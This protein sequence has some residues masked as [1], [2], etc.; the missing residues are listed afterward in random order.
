[1]DLGNSGTGVRL[2]LGLL[3][4]CPFDAV[5][6]GDESLRSRP[7]KRVTAPLSSMGARFESLEAPDRLPIH[8]RGGKL[9]PLQYD[10]PIASAQVK[11]A[12]MLA[13]LVGGVPVSLTEPGRSRDHTERMFR[14]VGVAVSSD[15]RDGRW[16]VSFADPPPVLPPLDFHVPGDFSS[17]AFLLVAGLLGVGAGSLTL[18]NVGLNPTRTG[19]LPLLARM[20]GEVAVEGGSDD[21]REPVG[22][23]KVAPAMLAGTEVSAEEV[24]PA[25]DEIPAL[26]ALASRARGVTRITGAGELRVKETDRIRALVEGM[27]ALGVDVEELE[28][29]LVLEGSDRPLRGTI[30]SHLDHRIAM[31]FGLLGALPGNE[32]RVLG[33]ECVDVSF[34]GFWET[35]A[36]IR[37]ERSRRATP[38][39]AAS[40]SRRGAVVTLDGPAGSGKSSTARE[41]ARRL[42]YR[43]LD[44]GALYRALTHALLEGG[45]GP[46]RW[47]EL[48]YGDLLGFDIRVDSGPDERL[49]VLLHGTMLEER[50]LRSREVTAHVSSLAR[51]PAV[52]AWLLER[53]REAGRQGALVA[54]G[55]D[56]GTVVFPDAEVKVF[57]VA[58]LQERARRRLRE[59]GT[60]NPSSSEV[61]EEAERIR[62]R[63]QR[64]SE[65]E[66]SPLRQAR[67]A[68]VLDTTGLTFEAQVEAIVARVRQRLAEPRSA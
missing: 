22:R 6:T 32:V 24:L 10:L 57:L 67:D 56:M 37:Q 52:R 60:E 11:S 26:V 3:A 62:G 14:Q 17:A 33:A 19:L 51:L 42:G 41:V 34:P 39:P 55:R 21:G 15:A 36:R 61:A 35:L 12:L 7:M 1:L 59:M 20:G 50:Q 25:I 13:G 54:E 2:L 28:D 58:D 64:D 40:G 49:R 63:D 45:V 29:G 23:L 31:A 53:Q 68:W 4:A 27:R 16:H 8:V 18:D 47:P 30:D 9:S 65:R 44:S 43:H 66:A 5:L 46:E 48:R 38:A